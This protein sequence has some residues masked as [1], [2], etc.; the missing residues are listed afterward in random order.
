MCAL[1]IETHPLLLTNHAR[2]R[3]AQRNLTLEQ[4]SYIMRY[5]QQTHCAGAILLTLRR[6][7]IPETLL[8]DDTIACLEGTTAVFSR[9]EPLLLTVWRNRQNGMR[10]IKRKPPYAV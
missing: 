9:E 10:H 4:I 8:K 7:D 1:Q 6:K 2:K 5:G 3:M